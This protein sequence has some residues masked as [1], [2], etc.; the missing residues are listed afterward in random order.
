MSEKEALSG[1][2]EEI[3]GALEEAT[4]RVISTILGLSELGSRVVVAGIG[5]TIG[6]V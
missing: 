2:T 4:E 1:M 6:V 5:N 3:E